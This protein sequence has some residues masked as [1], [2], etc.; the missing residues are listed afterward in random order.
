MLHVL[1]C[2]IIAVSDVFGGIYNPKGL[3]LADVFEHV[4]GKK[5]LNAYKNAQQITN[6]ELLTLDCDVLVPAALAGMAS[7]TR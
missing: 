1:G 5:L 7:S 2:K 3:D 4:K 6:D